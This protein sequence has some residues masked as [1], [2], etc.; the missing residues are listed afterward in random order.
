VEASKEESRKVEASTVEACAALLKQAVG[1]ARGEGRAEEIHQRA[2]EASA[3]E[4]EEKE[5]KV[6]REAAVVQAVV[7]GTAQW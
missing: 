3:A 1:K 7:P 2:T 5:E 6:G 4:N